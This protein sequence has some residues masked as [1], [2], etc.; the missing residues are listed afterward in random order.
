MCLYKIINRAVIGSF[1]IWREKTAGD[2][3][4]FAMIKNAFATDTFT[5][6]RLITTTAIGKILFLVRTILHP[7]PSP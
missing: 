1:R 2:L 4:I 6:A 3:A 7:A 5:A